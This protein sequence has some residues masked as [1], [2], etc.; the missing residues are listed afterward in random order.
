MC[1]QD[2][3]PDKPLA[4]G[5][6][7]LGQAAL[8][9]MLAQL[10]ESTGEGIYG[11][12]LDGR[13][14]FINRAGA[15]LLGY[16]PAELLGRNMHAVAHHSH[17]DGAHYPE[18]QC[19]IFKAFRE[20]LPCRIDSELFWRKNGSGL[21]VEYSSYPVIENGAV[22]GAVIT[23]TDVSARRQTEDALRQAHA[24]LE[25]RVSER[26]QAL[27][28]ALQQL[29]ELSAYAHGVREQER[30]RIAREVHDE[31][32]S[33]LV[34]LKMDVGWLDKRLGE[35][36]GRSAGEAQSMRERMRGKCQN[37]S[38][39]IESAVD[40]VGRII[41][42]LR[43]SILDHQGLWA[44]LDWQAHEFVQSAELALDWEMDVAGAVPLPEPSAIAI[45]RIFQE[46]LS[47]VGRHAQASRVAIAIRARAQDIS[48]TVQDNGQGAHADAFEAANAYGVMGMRER[49]RHLGGSLQISSQIGLG[50]TFHLRIQLLNK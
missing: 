22:Q 2:P 11:I 38:R 8:R 36:P 16:A 9:D 30:T 10:L 28:G 39:L 21:A 20:G 3:R 47:N 23:F 25:Q 1:K 37:M 5:Q 43:P 4:T 34:A 32:G 26:T 40:N 14:T 15:E 13:C 49:A 27:S 41:T 12:D 19:P 50:S 17:A 44:A 45:F 48:I 46:M 35:Q 29:R 6:P 31:L 7:G 24:V 42:D 33:L 18:Q